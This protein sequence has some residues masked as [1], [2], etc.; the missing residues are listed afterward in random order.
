MSILQKHLSQCPV[1]QAGDDTLLAEWLHP[2]NDGIDLPYSLAHAALPLG[3]ASLPH[4][5][6]SAETYIFLQGVGILYIE[7]QAHRVGKND[8]VVVPAHAEQYLENIGIEDLQFLC[9]VS[10]PWQAEEEEIL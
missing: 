4:R 9:I 5:L 2:K 7:G 10:P 3:E 1:F 6:K 8:L